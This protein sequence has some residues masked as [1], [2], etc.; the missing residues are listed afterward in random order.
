[1]SW[2]RLD[3]LGFL[4]LGEGSAVHEEQCLHRGCDRSHLLVFSHD[5][6]KTEHSALF[7]TN[8][9]KA[10]ILGQDFMDHYMVKVWFQEVTGTPETACENFLVLS[11]HLLCSF[12][13]GMIS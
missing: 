4:Y 7:E 9:I 6:R 3:Q 8:V 5:I 11:C 1:M 12:P 10:G 13:E 2:N